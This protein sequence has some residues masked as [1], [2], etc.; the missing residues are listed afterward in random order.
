MQEMPG[1]DGV[2]DY[3]DKEPIGEA[4]VPNIG[5]YDDFH[6]HIIDTEEEV[7]LEIVELFARAGDEV[8]ITYLEHVAAIKRLID[9]VNIYDQKCEAA[10]TMLEVDELIEELVRHIEAAPI[11]PDQREATIEY[12]RKIF[13]EE[14]EN[15]FFNISG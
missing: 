9:W 2:Q 1:D 6:A 4:V 14:A 8:A 5:C 10:T 13:R 3:P 15:R 12:A 7:S 11:P